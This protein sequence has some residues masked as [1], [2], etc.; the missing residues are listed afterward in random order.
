SS[1]TT[2]EVDAFPDNVRD[3]L[4]LMA[5]DGASLRV[6][7]GH[8]YQVRATPKAGSVPEVWLLGSSDYSTRLAAQL[9]LPYVFAHHFSGEGTER[10]LEL[11]RSTFTAGPELSE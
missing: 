11:Y 10:A 7:G 2:S 3:I 9:G 6:G 8:E 5:P 1:G 4:A